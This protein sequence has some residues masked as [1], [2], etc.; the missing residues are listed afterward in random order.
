[1]RGE[2]MTLSSLIFKKPYHVVALIGSGGKTTLIRTLARENRLSKQVFISNTLNMERIPESEV[3]FIDYNFREDYSLSDY[4]RPGVYVLA[5]DITPNNS[6]RGLPLEVLE[7]QAAHFDL[8]LIECDESRQR[9][10]KA[11][12]HNEPVLL[13]ATDMTLGILDISS[14]GLQISV[15]TVHNLDVFCDLTGK[16]V[17]DIITREDV[18]RLILDPSM[19]YRSAIGKRVLFINK[20][21]NPITLKYAADLGK[22]IAHAKGSPNIIVIGSLTKG[23]YELIKDT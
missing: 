22:E 4:K 5:Y 14:I 18:K 9:P 17:G 1:M 2:T 8:S 7:N 23:N 3:D 12:R 6:L 16:Q 13:E 15:D 10:L 21:E 11:W 19:M 20:A